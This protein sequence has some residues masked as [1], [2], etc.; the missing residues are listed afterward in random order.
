MEKL[1][2]ATVLALIVP[3]VVYLIMALSAGICRRR[4]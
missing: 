2:L 3:L 4:G 1:F